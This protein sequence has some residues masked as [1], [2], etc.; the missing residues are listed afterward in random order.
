MLSSSSGASKNH[1]S[2]VA[3]IAVMGIIISF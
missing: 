3:L 2:A 1:I